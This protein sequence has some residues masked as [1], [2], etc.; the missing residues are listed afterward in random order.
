MMSKRAVLS[1]LEEER[2]DLS[3]D[4]MGLGERA[5]VLSGVGDLLSTASPST[6]TG[7]AR[8]GLISSETGRISSMYVGDKDLLLLI[9]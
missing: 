3:T 2:E 6:S 1:N 8:V 4:L 9:N 7:R 5:R